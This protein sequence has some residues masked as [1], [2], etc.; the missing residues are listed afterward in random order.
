VDIQ[1][2]VECEWLETNGLGGFASST[3]CGLN[4]RRYHG[5]LTA[6]TKPPVGRMVL[7]SK[8][9]ETLVV[10]GQRYELSANRYA[11]AIHPHGFEYLSD[12]ALD[13]VPTFTYVAGGVTVRKSVFMVH[14]E[15]TT[16]V[17]YQ[18]D[19]RATLEV[20]ALIAFRDYHSLTHSNGALDPTVTQSGGGVMLKPYAGV[21][22][23]HFAHDAD[24]VDTFGCWYYNFEYDR[25]RERG[26]DNKEDLFSPCAFRFDHRQQCTIIASTTTLSA[27]AAPAMLE[28]EIRRRSSAGVAPIDK[29]V[30]R[31]LVRAADQYIVR[32][33]EYSSIIAGYHW[34]SDWGRDTMIALPGLTLVTGRFD[35]AREIL[36]AFSQVIDMG[37][38]PNRFPDAGETAEYNTVDATL[39][40]FEA[41]RAYAE[42]SGDLDFVLDT[43]YPKLKDIVEWHLKGTRYGI[44]VDD[45]GLLRCGVPGA[46]LTWMDSK[47][48]DWVV[49]PRHGKPVEIQALWYN[50]L[51]IM[52]N[53]AAADRDDARE[54][55]FR[56]IADLARASFRSKFWNDRL[57]CLYDCVNG[58]ETDASIRPN[59]IFTV[60]LP[61][62]LVEGERARRVVDT[63]RKHLLTPLGLRS[64]AP[65][66]P[67]YRPRYE[68]GVLERDSGY[69]QGTVWPWL[70]GPFITAYIK[71]HGRSEAA[72]DAALAWLTGIEAH[73]DTACL[74][75]IC[76]IAD[77][78]APHTPRGC[79]AQAW[80]VAEVLRAIVEDVHEIVP[81]KEVAAMV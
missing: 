17:Q 38:L 19:R 50:A 12:F 54:V 48:G 57:S 9:E 81:A 65:G 51:R 28:G 78:E 53:F 73:L 21:P 63:V 39:W 62:P 27:S 56:S 75:H 24:V 66:D 20:R 74:G 55:F 70:L 10:D 64:L 26:L 5:L 40:F 77:A 25:E 68:G 79:V 4:T 16:V 76:E 60:S 14:G 35:V 80:S 67:A 42:Y 61:H 23:L 41:I 7:L 36:L 29:P 69:H 8:L 71:V 52:Q 32:R 15:N 18:M 3:V 46:Q 49:T 13:L 72:R 30:V 33:G 34:F 37:M 11:G 58:T 43:L 1:K 6:A 2:A 31:R 47:I 59:Q 44:A 45:D 22:E